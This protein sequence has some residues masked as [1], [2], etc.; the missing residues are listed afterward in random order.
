[1]H[2]GHTPPLLNPA[3]QPCAADHTGMSDIARYLVRCKLVNS[4]LSKLD[5]HPENHRDWKSSF[6]NAIEG[7]RLTASL[8]LDLLVE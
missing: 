2:I 3:Q 4:G 8:E 1:M 6:T 5:D 7:L